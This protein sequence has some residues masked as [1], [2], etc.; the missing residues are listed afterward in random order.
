M[1]GLLKERDWKYMRSI[2]DELLHRLCADI[3]RSAAKLASAATDNPH[4]QYL[5]LSRFIRDSDST[6]AACFND[7]RRSQL[8]IKIINLRHYGLLTDHHITNLSPEAQE[9]L[10]KVESP[11]D[12][13]EVG[14]DQDH[15]L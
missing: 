12:G 7:W 3:N 6:I 9:W 13:N 15:Y 10:C 14:S 11:A 1:E 4:E 5:A 8:A 2:H